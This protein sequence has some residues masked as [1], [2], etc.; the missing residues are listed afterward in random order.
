MLF[1]AGS[2]DYPI[3]M[4]KIETPSQ[5][6]QSI[7]RCRKA[8]A[9]FMMGS[10]FLFVA[11]FLCLIFLLDYI[12]LYALFF[13]FLPIIGFALAF[14]FL[15]QANQAF[16]KLQ[17]FQFVNMEIKRHPLRVPMIFDRDVQAYIKA[18]EAK[19]AGAAPPAPAKPVYNPNPIA[20]VRTKEGVIKQEHIAL[21]TVN[22]PRCG[23]IN[24]E[25]AEF[26]SQCGAPMPSKGKRYEKERS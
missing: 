17:S 5:A 12:G 20:D 26:C 19:L 24:D 7:K 1:D 8:Y 10:P 21:S 22:C 15:Y 3:D 23:Y 2:T 25:E 11:A 16:A 18:V 14:F 9:A 13:L 6:L 4:K